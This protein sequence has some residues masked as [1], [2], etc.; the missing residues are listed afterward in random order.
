MIVTSVTAT[1]T[2]SGREIS[3]KNKINEMMVK[4][5]IKI[6]MKRPL[7][8]RAQSTEIK[9]KKFSI[10]LLPEKSILKCRAPRTYRYSDVVNVLLANGQSNGDFAPAGDDKCHATSHIKWLHRSMNIQLYME[11]EM[12]MHP[13]A[14]EHKKIQYLNLKKNKEKKIMK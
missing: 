9:K 5:K 11:I 6:P 4:T 13:D 10:F 1:V 12:V 2:N 8:A 14:K 3:T 7:C